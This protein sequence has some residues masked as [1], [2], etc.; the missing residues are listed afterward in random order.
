MDAFSC[1]LVKIA[2]ESSQK[3]FLDTS[4]LLDDTRAAYQLLESQL[5]EREHF[6]KIR[7]TELLGKHDEELKAG[8]FVFY[9]FYM[10][11]F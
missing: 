4:R 8:I 5:T 11:N 2:H 9:K 6:Y 7:E 10:T 1:P 3:S